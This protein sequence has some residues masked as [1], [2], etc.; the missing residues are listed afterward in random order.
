LIAS[1]N[2]ECENPAQNNKKLT[3]N[4]KSTF[5]AIF[6]SISHQGTAASSM[7]IIVGD[8]NYNVAGEGEQYILVASKLEH[9]SYNPGN[10]QAYDFALLKLATPVTLPSAKA[11]LVCLPTD[12][13]QTFEGATLTIRL[14]F[15]DHLLKS[16][17]TSLC[18]FLHS[19]PLLH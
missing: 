2:L 4:N 5:N 9:P 3:K 17:F 6:L 11:G 1:C 12:L 15:Q 18:K 7:R 16:M 19:V 10:S 8:H 13:S 14:S